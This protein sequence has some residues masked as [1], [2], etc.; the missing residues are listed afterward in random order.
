MW[1]YRVFAT[2]CRISF[3]ACT[4]LG[5][6]R[7][8]LRCNCGGS[9]YLRGQNLPTH[10]VPIRLWASH[11]LSIMWI[12]VIGWDLRSGFNNVLF[13][14]LGKS[15]TLWLRYRPLSS[16][17][18]SVQF[19]TKLAMYHC[20]VD[21]TKVSSAQCEFPTETARDGGLITCV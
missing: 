3:K 13:R 4:V 20:V 15:A 6:G 16:V 19:G 17:T 8:V 7:R 14:E 12:R 5:C 2:F 11:D 18:L 21:R 9:Q 10:R 1:R